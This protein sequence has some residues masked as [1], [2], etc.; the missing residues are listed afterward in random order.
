[1]ALVLSPVDFI[2]IEGV[3]TVEQQREYVKKGVSKTLASRHLSGHAV[4]IFP[5]GG[6]WNN[7]RCWLPVLDAVYR[8]A[9]Q[10]GVTLRFGITWTDN[11]HDVPARF[12]DAP[13]IELPA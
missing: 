4:D 5:V 1:M 13:H 3:R 12:L 6:D 8:A 11:P 10:F 9:E 2:V 7:Y